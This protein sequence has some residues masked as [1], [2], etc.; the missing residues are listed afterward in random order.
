MFRWA[1]FTPTDL[2]LALGAVTPTMRLALGKGAPLLTR[3]P[4]TYTTANAWQGA[5]PKDLLQAYCDRQLRWQGFNSTPLVYER[6][7]TQEVDTGAQQIEPAAAA[8]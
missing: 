4:H 3:L 8:R 2:V 1:S 7:S 5:P 6:L